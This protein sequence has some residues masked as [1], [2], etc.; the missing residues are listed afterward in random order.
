MQ[1][2]A[3]AQPALSVADKLSSTFERI[4]LER[5]NKDSLVVPSFP[6]VARDC[7]EQL[8]KPDFNSRNVAQRLAQDPVL[9]ARLLKSANSAV[10][11]GVTKIVTVEQA[12]ARLGATRIKSLLLEASAAELFKSRDREI[13]DACRAV[14]DHSLAVAVLARDLVATAG[15][16]PEKQE[17]AFLVG[18]LHDVGKP[19][20]AALM[21][22]GERM[23]GD[24]SKSWVTLETWLDV[25][26]KLHRKVGNKLAERWGLP[27]EVAAAIRDSVE[28]DSGS[29]DSIGNYARFANALAK[30]EGLYVGAFDAKDNEAV[31]MIGRS[32]LG[33]DDEV[34]KKLTFN[35]RDRIK[36]APQ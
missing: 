7:L 1:S 25:V 11:S 8:R 10:V 34:V 36:R 33:C 16:E 28:Y 32:L 31:M 23:L 15:Q 27:E 2:E 29:R 26:G 9:A 6:E 12:V 17:I 14:W 5:L 24:G 22:E 3:Q 21:L 13:N 35:L 19:V 4:I 18:L 20:V 30:R